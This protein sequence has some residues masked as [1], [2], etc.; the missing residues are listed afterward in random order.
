[1]ILTALRDGSGSLIGFAKVTRDLT[2]RRASEEATRLSEERI[3][4]MIEAVKD[5]AIFMLDP[6]GNVASWNEGAQHIKQYRAEEIIGQHFSRF[7]PEQD[8]LAGKCERGL[9]VA[10]RDG[11]FEDEG[12]RVRKDGTLFWAN[13]VITVIRNP[14]GALLGYAKV[15]RDLTERRLL[16]DEK[17]RLAQA[18]E[19]IRLRDE[20]LSIASHELKTPLTAMQLQLQSLLERVKAVDDQVASRLG[21]AIRSGARLADLIETLLDVSRIA[22]GRLE[23]S[24]TKFDLSE[25]IGEAV[26]RMSGSAAQAGC[27][28]DTRI[29]PGVTGI[30]DRVRIEQVLANLLSNAFRY[31]AGMPVTIILKSDGAKAQLEVFDEGPGIPETDLSRI[32]ERFERASSTRNY[33]GMGL[34]LYV[35]RQ[36]VDAH[37]GSVSARNRKD[38]GAAFTVVLP[39][40]PEPVARVEP[41]PP[42]ELR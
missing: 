15:T 17:V 21:R 41:K 31:G 10:A 34:G 9:E 35:T 5:H 38:R 33:G 13:V 20:F 2:E 39:L 22:T 23:L 7:Y 3:R 37:G 4:L 42:K 26:E 40:A 12:W 18:Q 24:P 27:P 11:R 19:A 14:E 28:I 29:Q 6:E 36:I 16:E 30:W 25:A 1:V 8:V 32:F